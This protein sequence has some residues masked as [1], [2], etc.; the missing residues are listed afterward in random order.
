[1]KRKTILLGVA[2]MMA[3]ALAACSSGGDAS[4]SGSAPAPESVS[5]AAGESVSAAGAASEAMS[6]AA[7]EKT[8]TLEE[9][10]AYNGK[11]GQPA[12]VAVNGVV[13]D[14]TDVPEWA[15]G[16]HKNG[17]TA[18]QDLTEQITNESPH[19]LSVLDDLPVVGKLA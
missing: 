11:D 14:V 6:E 7:G 9:L 19:G 12:Y 4:A 1:M 10:A 3:V 2:L 15:G 17:L 13:Y 8:F 18:G 16:E 5:A